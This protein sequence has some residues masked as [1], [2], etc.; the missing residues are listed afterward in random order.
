M[1][2]FNVVFSLVD[3]SKRFVVE[4][5]SDIIKKEEIEAI[6]VNFLNYIAAF[7][8]SELAMVKEDLKDNKILCEENIVCNKKKLENDLYLA[9]KM[10]IET[11]Q[12]LKVVCGFEKDTR[13]SLTIAYAIVYNFIG[14][15]LN[16]IIKRHSSYY[17]RET[18]IKH[19]LTMLVLDNVPYRY[20]G[21]KLLELESV[22]TKTEFI[23]VD[24][25]NEVL[26]KT[27]NHRNISKRFP[28]ARCDKLVNNNKIERKAKL[29]FIKNQLNE[30]RQFDEESQ[31]E[32]LNDL[33]MF[34][35]EYYLQL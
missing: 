34:F 28:V 30:I 2:T 25:F 6:I 19:L 22:I 11:E 8:G 16:I 3:Y 20:G 18:T 35:K 13:C 33:V 32:K 15:Y 26:D 4:Y 24:K 29:K 10:Y 21:N 31:K 17:S 1:K 27:I 14:T 5:K 7:Y 12:P 23:T 9:I